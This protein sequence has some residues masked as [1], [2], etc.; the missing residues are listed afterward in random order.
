VILTL[1]FCQAHSQSQPW[2]P[3]PSGSSADLDL[4]T[5]TPAHPISIPS[6]HL[7]GKKRWRLRNHYASSSVQLRAG[8]GNL[9]W[10]D[11]RCRAGVVMANTSASGVGGRLRPSRAHRVVVVPGPYNL[12]I[13][14][15][16]AVAAIVCALHPIMHAHMRALLSPV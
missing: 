5:T 16:Y 1:S 10:R 11:C 9:T 2:I 13:S 4:S 7:G 14:H 12:T 6:P 15:M 3:L 8:A